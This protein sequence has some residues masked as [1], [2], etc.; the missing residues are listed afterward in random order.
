M[1]FLRDFRT[2]SRFGKVQSTGAFKDLNVSCVLALCPI[3]SGENV[4]MAVVVPV[5][6]LWSRT[7][8][9]PYAWYDRWLVSCFDPLRSSQL[10]RIV[11]GYILAELHVT[12]A[13][14]ADHEIVFTITVNIRHGRAGI[15][16]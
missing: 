10:R 1:V 14:L 5:H 9:S 16:R 3:A 7:G 11:V 12:L 8:A 4:E 13:E 2:H 6:K 15:A